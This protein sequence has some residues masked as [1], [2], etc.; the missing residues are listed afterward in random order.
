MESLLSVRI[1]GIEYRLYNHIYA[2][3]KDGVIL[4]HLKPITPKV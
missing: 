4:R 2:V 1:N 3:S